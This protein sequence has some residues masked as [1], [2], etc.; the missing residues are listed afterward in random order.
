MLF[1][2]AFAPKILPSSLRIIEALVVSQ[3]RL[4]LPPNH[5]HDLLG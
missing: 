1:D 4:D 2:A 3:A 5:C